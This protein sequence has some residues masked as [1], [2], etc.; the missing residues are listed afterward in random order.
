MT[1]RLCSWV[2]TLLQLLLVNHVS[3]LAV[4]HWHTIKMLD[5]RRLQAA[6]GTFEPGDVRRP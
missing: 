1:R 4:S 2:E 3:Q 5:K 6:F